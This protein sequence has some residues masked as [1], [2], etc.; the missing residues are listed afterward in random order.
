M[1]VK[2]NKF[3][4]SVLNISYEP[5]DSKWFVDFHS[6]NSY[7]I[8]F[9]TKGCGILMI[10]D[11]KYE[12]GEGAFYI[13]GPSVLHSQQ[14][15]PDDPMEEY[16]FSVSVKELVSESRNETDM[17]FEKIRENPFFTDIDD[18]NGGTLC[19]EML[20]EAFFLNGA[21]DERIRA[22]VTAVMISICRKMNSTGESRTNSAKIS[23]PSLMRKL[24]TY[25][26][27]FREDITCEKIAGEL[28]IS[29]RQLSRIMNNVY[30]MSFSKKVISLRLEYA[31]E[32]LKSGSLSI[33]KVAEQSGFSS[34]GSFCKNFKA[35]EGCSP[36]Q[37]RKEASGRKRQQHNEN[38]RPD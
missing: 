32:L 12:L 13:T 18:F 16:G 34:S 14:S 28:Y 30:G 36:T 25:L 17:L 37:Y 5:P 22:L 10:E 20:D 29:Q 21:Y 24:D 38:S 4:I 26:R 7:E 3:K 11:Q 1:N 8:H 23:K 2:T 15:D 35:A 19:R 6:H 31:R 33:E 9:I 27:N